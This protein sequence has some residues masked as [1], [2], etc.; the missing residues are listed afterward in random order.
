MSLLSL[1]L[2]LLLLF[3]GG[4]RICINVFMKRVGVEFLIRLRFRVLVH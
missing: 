4:I 1:L 3:I 2:G